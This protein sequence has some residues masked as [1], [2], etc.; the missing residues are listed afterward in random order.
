MEMTE[1]L[2]QLHTEVSLAPEK[3]AKT[4]EQLTLKDVAAELVESQQQIQELR[5]QLMVTGKERN[6]QVAS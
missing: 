5:S 2:N 3:L 1:R 4:K 6:R